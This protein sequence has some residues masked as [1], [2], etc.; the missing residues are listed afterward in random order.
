MSLRRCWKTFHLKFYF[1]INVKC[2]AVLLPALMAYVFTC[3]PHLY[4]AAKLAARSAERVAR[5][6]DRVIR[7]SAANL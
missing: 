1:N 4:V 6:R 7:K 5:A 2:N 3:Q